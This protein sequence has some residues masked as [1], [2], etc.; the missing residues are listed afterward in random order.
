MVIETLVRFSH[1]AS[2][3]D[4]PE[5]ILE[6]L[7]DAAM[8]HSS[9]QAGAILRLRD[10]ATIAIV[11]S[12]K[13]PKRL[14]AWTAEVDSVDA[15]LGAR[16][17]QAAGKRFKTSRVLPLMS[18]HALF[19]ALVLLYGDDAARDADELEVVSA[20]VDLAAN[21]F[22]RAFQYRELQ[23]AY[24]ELRLS[25][26]AQ[27]R[28]YKLGVLGQMAAGVA[29]DLKNILNPISIHLTLLARAAADDP[30]SAESIAAMREVLQRG[31][32][33]IDRL[34]DFSR[35][36]PERPLIAQ[37]VDPLVRQAIDMARARLVSTGRYQ[38]ALRM[39]LGAPPPVHVAADE[40]VSAVVN[41]VVNAIDAM[42]DVGSAI[43]VS[44]GAAD[45]EVWIRVRDDGP[46]IPPELA[47]R[48]FEPFFTTKGEAGTGLGLAN[49][50]AFA[51]R[52]GGDVALETAPGEGAT[53]TIR[54]ALDPT[55]ALTPMSVRQSPP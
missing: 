29:H 13:L 27:A 6:S 50:Y 48:V 20:L 53:F 9:A 51:R 35:Q 45:Q 43:T 26:E 52:F 10:D 1:L 3:S 15:E 21:A 36:L 22:G 2:A 17:C 23:R 46:G 4:E 28:A 49:V 54:L 37:E 16:L 39:E 18:H 19:G 12:R 42:G 34:R 44:T 47:K 30:S 40:L 11:S 55:H 41:L 24:N 31:V 7:A 33:T 25:R 32:A 38:L 8:A 14:S 5:P